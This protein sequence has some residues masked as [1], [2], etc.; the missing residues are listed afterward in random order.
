MGVAHFPSCVVQAMVTNDLAFATQ[1]RIR[2]RQGRA[3]LNGSGWCVHVA[4]YVLS[5]RI[6][7]HSES[8]KV[9]DALVNIHKH[10]GI[11]TTL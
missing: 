4:V 3:I 2:C 10:C 1:L 9:A 11:I 7:P 5:A 8:I 6:A